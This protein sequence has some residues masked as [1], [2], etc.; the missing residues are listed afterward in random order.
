[1]STLI[2]T[3]LSLGVAALI[4]I[5][6]NGHGLFTGMMMDHSKMSMDDSTM[7]AAQ[8]VK[9]VRPSDI[10]KAEEA[11][12]V[13]ADSAAAAMANHKHGSMDHSAMMA[14]GDGAQHAHQKLDVS[15]MDS[16]PNLE[17]SVIRDA[18]SGWNLKI[19]TTNFAFAPDRVNGKHVMGEGHA[20]IY[21]NGQKLAR[22]YG[23]HFHIPALDAGEHLIEVTLN[24]NTHEEYAIGDERISRKV[25]IT[26]R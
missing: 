26:E 9:V 19:A 20:H 14:S 3:I 12:R 10:E 13:G 8:P 7:N 18:M 21:I 11:K 6:V 16:P 4:F 25:S 1:M 17:I 2:T 15:Q 5:A 24:T 23:S 22:V